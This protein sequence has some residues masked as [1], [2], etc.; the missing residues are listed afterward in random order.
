MYMCDGSFDSTDSPLSGK[1]RW[2]L[3]GCHQQ[4]VLSS[5]L[6]STT[7]GKRRTDLRCSCLGVLVLHCLVTAYDDDEHTSGIMRRDHQ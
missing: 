6:G 1:L 2:T 7:N 4:G 3:D 5:C